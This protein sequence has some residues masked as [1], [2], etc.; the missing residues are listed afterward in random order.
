MMYL[1]NHQC[2]CDVLCVYICVHTQTYI[3]L[4]VVMF[5]FLFPVQHCFLNLIIH[6][7]LFSKVYDL[8]RI[9]LLALF[10]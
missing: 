3:I 9:S 2:A 5:A 7:G 1:S 4:F 10:V 8:D 6:D